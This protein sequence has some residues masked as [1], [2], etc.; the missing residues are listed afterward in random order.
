MLSKPTVLHTMTAHI[1]I[2]NSAEALCITEEFSLLSSPAKGL[3]APTK[4]L[5]C[6]ECLGDSFSFLPHRQ[7]LSME[8]LKYLGERRVL[9]HLLLMPNT[10]QLKIL[11]VSGWFI[12]V[13]MLCFFPPSI[14]NCLGLGGCAMNSSRVSPL[15]VWPSRLWH[16]DLEHWMWQG[17]RPQAL[18]HF[19]RYYISD[20]NMSLHF[21]N[22][23]C[24][25]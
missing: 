5:C 7:L 11:S 4:I 9:S 19:K 10:W 16:S 17:L 18:W 24:W 1:L 12:T 14:G 20:F 13:L 2:C 8:N 22:W 21:G 23:K 15:Y 6:L 3:W 25:M